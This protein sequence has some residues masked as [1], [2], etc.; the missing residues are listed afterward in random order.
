MSGPRVISGIAKGKRLKT[1]KAKNLRPATD[2]VKEALFNI[3]ATRVPES[4]FLDLFA[5]TG[6]I[7]IEALSRGAQKIIFVE[8][9][10][11]NAALIE[12]NLKITGF[13]NQAQIYRCDVTKA[14]ALLKK[15]G[16]RFDLIFVDPPF[17]QGL[18]E[19]TLD[20]VYRLK[21]LFPGGLVIARSAFGE[22]I[23]ASQRPV[24]EERYGDSVLRFYTGESTNES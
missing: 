14:L 2:Y 18:V 17:R 21:L 15:G 7:G 8:K 5:G 16:Y 3:I 6:S 23:T 4:I 19:P 24:R 13:L 22:E 12:E 9:N 10:P 20:C 1:R 11:Q